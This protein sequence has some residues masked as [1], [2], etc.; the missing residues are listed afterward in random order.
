MSSTLPWMKRM[1]EEKELGAMLRV[2]AISFEGR[3]VRVIVSHASAAMPVSGG[4]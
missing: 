4:T 1:S 2:S 3:V